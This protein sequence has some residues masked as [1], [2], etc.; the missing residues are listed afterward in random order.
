MVGT[1]ITSNSRFKT[2]RM[3]ITERS[4]SILLFQRDALMPI[5]PGSVRIYSISCTTSHNRR[6]VCAQCTHLLYPRNVF[7][8]LLG[9]F[10]DHK[11]G[12]EHIR[13]R[14]HPYLACGRV[15]AVARRNKLITLYL[16]SLICAK[17]AT[18]FYFISQMRVNSTFTV[19]DIPSR[20]THV[21]R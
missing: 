15:Y 10:H 6:Q 12:L 3:H 4:V 7:Y 2:Q 14:T 16:L 9:H 13:M 17:A 19:Y 5:S 21:G 20:P 18:A 8:P 1:S 11:V